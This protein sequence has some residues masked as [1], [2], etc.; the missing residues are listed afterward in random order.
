MASNSE[1]GHAKNVA[2]FENLITS[3]TAFGTAYN[4]NKNSIKLPKL[5]SVFAQAKD[6]LNAVNIAHAAYSNA[7]AARESAFE[8]FG[9][10]TTRINN[11]LK[12][13]D[14]TKQ[15]EDSAKTIVRKLQ[16]RRASAKI[17]DEEKQAL[18]AQGKVVNQVSAAQ[19]SFDNR[20][21]NFDKL[22]M[23]LAS[24]P[25]YSPNE[26]DLKLDTLKAYHNLLKAKNNDVL[27]ATVELSN[28]RI[29]RNELLYKPLTGL[30]DVALDSK[31]YVKSVFG[32]SS[33][34]YKQISKLRFVS[35]L[36]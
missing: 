26:E 20:I 24:V 19:M 11:A 23:L 34:N 3:I 31:V 29:K 9:K 12:A 32:A 14:T 25:A 6:Q 33:P 21:E 18:E 7:V 1:T 30:V 36:E 4:P 15:I 2:N 5:Q 13:S 10:L 35:K 27:V 16:G 22:I 28:A 17:S 8:P